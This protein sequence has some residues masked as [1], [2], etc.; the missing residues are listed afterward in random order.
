[1]SRAGLGPASVTEAGALLVDELGADQLSMGLLAERV[2]VKT[3]SLY[4]HVDNLADLTHR[5]AVLAATELGDCV[6]DVAQGRAGRDALIAVVRAMRTYVK[7]HP[8]RY[9]VMNAV[10]PSGP[11][12]PLVVAS[13]RLLSSLSAVLRGYRISSTEE[14]H[15]LRMLR[16]MLHGFVTLEIEEGFRLDTDVNESFDWMIDAID[17]TLRSRES[18]DTP[19]YRD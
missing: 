17:Q 18:D 10:T 2:G 5:I 19:G 1:M 15:A 13:N 9:R 4:K 11:E 14:I 3:P 8:G 7:G 6:R 12:D 16:S